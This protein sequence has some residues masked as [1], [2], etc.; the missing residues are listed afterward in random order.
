MCVC[1]FVFICMCIKKPWKDAQ[2]TNK[3]SDPG[4][5]KE[6]GSWGS[7]WE[8]DFSM[9]LVCVCV[10]VQYIH[11]VKNDIMYIIF[12]SCECITYK[13]LITKKRGLK[14]REVLDP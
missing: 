11:M 4:G 1:V 7:R 14:E 13:T 3:S 12:E 2:E 10:C 6:L 8:K 5:G 9:S